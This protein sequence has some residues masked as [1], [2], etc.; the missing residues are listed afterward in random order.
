MPQTSTLIELI[1]ASNISPD[2]AHPFF[3][4]LVKR[5]PDL[6]EKKYFVMPLVSQPTIKII[7]KNVFKNNAEVDHHIDVT[8][9][10]PEYLIVT[11]KGRLGLHVGLRTNIITFSHR[12]KNG[13]DYTQSYFDDRVEPIGSAEEE[14]RQLQEFFDNVANRR[15]TIRLVS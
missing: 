13:D 2:R 12:F 8:R 3:V 14:L 10:L 5:R 9:N 6:F 7:S 15:R 1:N 4:N 11:T